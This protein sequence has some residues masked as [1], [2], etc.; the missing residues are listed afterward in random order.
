VPLVRDKVKHM[1]CM[2]K[3]NSLLHAAFDDLVE[4]SHDVTSAEEA[5]TLAYQLGMPGETALLSPACASFD[6][7]GSYE[8]R[9]RAFKSAVR[10]L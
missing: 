4:S 8:H 7:F 6:L 1:I 9:G 3:N 5:V 2:G 10:A